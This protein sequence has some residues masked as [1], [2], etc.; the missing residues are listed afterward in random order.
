MKYFATASKRINYHHKSHNIVHV[1]NIVFLNIITIEINLVECHCRHLNPGNPRGIV[2]CQLLP[3]QGGLQT[4]LN[5]GN[6]QD[7]P[8]LGG[9]HQHHIG[10]THVHPQH[11]PT[12]H[13][14]CGQQVV[15]GVGNGRPHHMVS[16]TMY[17]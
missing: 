14:Y 2:N 3:D 9:S 15:H 16:H 8:G 6:C 13:I 7:L 1:L 11:A 5:P 10:T 17:H 4:N 12:P